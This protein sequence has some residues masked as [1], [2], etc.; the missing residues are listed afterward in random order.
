LKN[1][2]AETKNVGNARNTNSREKIFSGSSLRI[3]QFEPLGDLACSL[4]LSYALT[5]QESLDDGTN[6]NKLARINISS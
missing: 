4:Q 1:K 5:L 6:I 3:W 2:Q